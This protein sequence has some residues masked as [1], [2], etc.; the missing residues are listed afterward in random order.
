MDG[1]RLLRAARAA[2]A[3]SARIPERIAGTAWIRKRVRAEA[4]SAAASEIALRRQTLDV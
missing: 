3:A 2:S 4:R 1:S